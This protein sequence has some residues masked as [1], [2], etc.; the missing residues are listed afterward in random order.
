MIGSRT[1][2]WKPQSKGIPNGL[3]VEPRRAATPPPFSV[4]TDPRTTATIRATGPTG[5]A[6]D[7]AAALGRR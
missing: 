3:E 7:P 1:G 6:G 2:E 4:W 5:A